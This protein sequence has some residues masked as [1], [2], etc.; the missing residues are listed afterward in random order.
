MTSVSAPRMPLTRDS[1]ARVS[2][3]VAMVVVAAA[4][5]AT[6]LTT[7]GP[8]AAVSAITLA[9]LTIVPGDIVRR[10]ALPRW[11]IGSPGLAVI[12]VVL[13]GV[14]LVAVGLSLALAGT[15]MVVPVA[16]ALALVSGLGIA[17]A[18][19]RGGLLLR[20][21]RSVV[22]VAAVIVLACLGFFLDAR[23]PVVPDRIALGQLDTAVQVA[24]SGQIPELTPS[25]GSIVAFPT[26]YLFYD[27]I[28]GT[29]ILLGRHDQGAELVQLLVSLRLP[30]IALFVT[31]FWLAA[32]AVLRATFLHAGS[33]TR[34][35]SAVPWSLS[36]VAGVLPA[37]LS[38][39]ILMQAKLR[40]PLTEGIALG[41][42]G[43]GLWMAA[44]LTEVN[45]R[46]ARRWSILSGLAIALVA[47]IHLPAAVGAATI[48]GSW[49]LVGF[50]RHAW[51]HGSRRS[52]GRGRGTAIRAAFGRV[53]PAVLLPVIGLL[54][55]DIAGGAPWRDCWVAPSSRGR[56]TP[57]RRFGRSF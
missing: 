56:V 43:A 54:I 34:M 6:V 17:V 10:A 50:L 45:G 57:K 22:V 23:L 49:L 15:F 25:F 37:V 8:H 39:N 30:T 28:V 9:V 13:S 46:R 11:R 12:D 41:L 3:A 16:L 48:V 31:S 18:H 26:H 20:I 27:V 2:V 1:A 24:T 51:G 47:G 35:R 52:G 42:I 4:A 29:L 19:M 40:E 44:S 33:A 14:I 36:I 38:Y 55:Y 21:D 5:A 53:A 32:S 7:S